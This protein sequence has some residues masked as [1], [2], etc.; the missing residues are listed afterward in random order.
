MPDIYDR[1]NPSDANSKWDFSKYIPDIVVVNL[2]QNDSWLVNLPEHEQFKARFGKQKPSEDFIITAYK[3]F[4][5]SVRI[6]YPKAQIICALGDMDATQE[7]SKWPGYIQAAV[8]MLKDNKIV[9]HFFP[10][11]G[12]PGHPIIKDHETMAN[13]LIQ[14]IETKK[15]WK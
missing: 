11:K 6:K 15:Y 7:G 13:D 2:F 10:Y 9:T 4:I 14:F 3:N 1:L 5:Q 8:S 12:A